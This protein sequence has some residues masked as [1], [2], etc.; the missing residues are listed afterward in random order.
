MLFSFSYAFSFWFSYNLIF[1]SFATPLRLS[2]RHSRVRFVPFGI[3]SWTLVRHGHCSERS[4]VTLALFQS[5]SVSNIWAAKRMQQLFMNFSVLLFYARHFCHM[6][7]LVPHTHTYARTRINT[8]IARMYVFDSLYNTT[9]L[10]L[11]LV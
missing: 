5:V 3:G 7:A 11:L 1:N 9:Q 10:H 2:G 4:T 8:N 6:F